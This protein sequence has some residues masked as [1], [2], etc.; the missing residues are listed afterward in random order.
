MYDHKCMYVYT[1]E[2]SSVMYKFPKTQVPIR[3]SF[4]HESTLDLSQQS[5]DI[6]KI[7]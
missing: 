3:K 6:S 7:T 1:C 4:V 5:L 2:Y